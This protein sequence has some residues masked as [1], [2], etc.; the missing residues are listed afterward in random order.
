MDGGLLWKSL[1]ET[2]KNAARKLL[3][4]NWDNFNDFEK[5]LLKDFPNRRRLLLQKAKNG[6]AES[7]LHYI[8]EK[9]DPSQI[10]LVINIRCPQ[11]RISH[12]TG[13]ELHNAVQKLINV[14]MDD[15]L[16]ISDGFD[17]GYQIK[18][19]TVLLSS[20]YMVSLC[21]NESPLPFEG[22][23]HL[24]V[25]I[26]LVDVTKY[27][28]ISLYLSDLFTTSANQWAK[29]I[30]HQPW[31]MID[32]RTTLAFVM[33]LHNRLC[34]DSAVH[35]LSADTV[36]AISMALPECLISSAEVLS[37]IVRKITPLIAGNSLRNELNS[38]V[39]NAMKDSISVGNPIPQICSRCKL[40]I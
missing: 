10:L 16:F 26:V 35:S 3:Q 5:G 17:S 28:N 9:C 1:P 27:S 13:Q 31:K 30:V 40:L 37:R 8:R 39:D 14:G 6:Y 4:R 24:Q 2:F 7:K 21:V 18:S 25:Q 15:T 22:I 32:P 33:G 11:G 34:E 12:S 36:Q 29:G 23:K 38:L 20:N 19:R